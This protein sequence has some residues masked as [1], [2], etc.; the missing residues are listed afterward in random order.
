MLEDKSIKKPK[1]N[2]TLKFLSYGHLYIVTLKKNYY[3][4]PILIKFFYVLQQKYKICRGTPSL[5]HL[6]N[7]VK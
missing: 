4:T 3:L 5:S 7:N 1:K 6:Y 2:F